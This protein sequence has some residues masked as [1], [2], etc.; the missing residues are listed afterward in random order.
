M[1]DENQLVEIKW[2]KKTKGYYESKGYVF[3]RYGDSFYVKAKDMQKNSGF[4]VVI[5]CDYC[6]EPHSVSYSNY[7]KHEDKTV[8]VCLKCQGFKR[9]NKTKNKRAKKY[10][11]IVR[12]I[13]E[14]S[15][16]ILITE[17]SE[18]QNVFM[19]IEYICPKHGVQRKVLD[20]MIRGKEKCLSCSYEE[21]GMN[22]R[23]SAEYVKS[24][25]ESYNNNKLL[26]PEDYIGVFEKKS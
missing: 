3:T 1:F 22:Q 10:F 7:N 9:W 5:I 17:E 2:A 18:F 15:G 20:S 16:Y 14:E 6:G 12:K 11:D 21:R 4:K 8:D 26:N 19:H 13:C 24:V 25:I 23:H